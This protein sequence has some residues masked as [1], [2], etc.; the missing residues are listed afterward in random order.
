MTGGRSSRLEPEALLP[1]SDV[2]LAALVVLMEGDS[3]GYAIIHAVRERTEG[4]IEMLPGNFYNVL[5]RMLRNGLI[6]P[7]GQPAPGVSPGKP[8]RMFGIT[9]FGRRVARA[10][11][12][13]IVEIAES[14]DVRR[15]AAESERR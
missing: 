10:E 13:R 12:R 6:E 3:Y 5:Q 9:A 1:L 14:P 2:E 7:S 4:R 15:L 8:R 11:A